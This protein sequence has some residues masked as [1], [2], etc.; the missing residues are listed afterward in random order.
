VLGGP[1]AASVASAA[2]ERALAGDAIAAGPG[3]VLAAAAGA[4]PGRV[5]GGGD[6]A[7]A[8]ELDVLKNVFEKYFQAGSDYY[9]NGWRSEA[10]WCFERA[11]Q[12]RPEFTGLTR[13]IGLLRDYDNPVWKRKRWKSPRAGVEAGFRRKQELYDHAC[14]QALLKIGTRHARGKE[15]DLAD[16]AHARFR[17]AL[18]I[19]GGPYQLDASDCVVV[20]KAGTIPPGFSARIVAD[21]LVTINGERWLRDS[22]LRRIAS[23]AELHE[24][25]TERCLVRTVT[26]AEDA[27]RLLDLLEQAYPAYVRELG[28]RRTG[29]RLGLFVFR[30]RAAYEEWC[31]ASDHAGFVKAA[32]FANSA[33]GF[34]VTFA[35]PQLDEVAIHEAAHLYHFDVYATAMPSWYDEGVAESFGDR[36]SMRIVEGKLTTL[37]APTKATLA[38]LLREGRLAIALDE[39][40]HGDALE[41]IQAGDDSAATFYLASWALYR[42]LR[43]SRDPRFASRFED[44]ESFALGSRWQR[45]EENADA[46]QL[47]DRLFDGVKP[48]LELA[49]TA[50]VAEPS[51]PP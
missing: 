14:A 41:R 9:Q 33:E 31:K 50:W 20:G 45:G 16:R 19:V 10:L 11:T 35:Q 40:L 21:D 42:F 13:F 37:L 30:D 4:E 15:P 6:E 47:F 44:W 7:R 48:E 5:A 12:V 29:R 49:F 36:H 23:V 18:E 28:E 43:E 32:G 2:G 25:R 38:P 24:A 26:A 3:L 8:Y 39:L 34:A 46:A 1:F 27:A 22:M 17:E 51:K